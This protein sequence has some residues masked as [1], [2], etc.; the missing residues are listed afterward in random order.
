MKTHTHTQAQTQTHNSLFIQLALRGFALP[1][2]GHNLH[3]VHLD[4]V[5]HLSELHVVQDERP[6]VVAEAVGIQGAL[7]DGRT[8]GHTHASYCSKHPGHSAVNRASEV[9]GQVVRARAHCC[10]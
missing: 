2:T 8:D 5:G 7:Q 3:L 4:E 10:C 1:V 6:H 9:R